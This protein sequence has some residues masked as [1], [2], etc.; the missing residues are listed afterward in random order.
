MRNILP[1]DSCL[2]FIHFCT[3]SFDDKLRH[4]RQH[5]EITLQN[6]NARKGIDSEDK[7]RGD[8]DRNEQEVD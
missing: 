1:L 3:Q 7:S 4:R 5:V 2:F 6:R 8:F